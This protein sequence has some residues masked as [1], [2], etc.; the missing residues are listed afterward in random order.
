METSAD[1]HKKKRLYI[2]PYYS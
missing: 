1:A 2:V